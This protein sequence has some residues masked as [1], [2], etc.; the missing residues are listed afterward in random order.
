MGKKKKNNNIIKE[1][2]KQNQDRIAKLMESKLREY[3]VIIPDTNI[4][5]IGVDTLEFDKLDEDVKRYILHSSHLF[6]SSLKQLFKEK[7]VVTTDLVYN[8]LNARVGMIKD[9]VKIAKSPNQTKTNLYVW[10]LKKIKVP[11]P[12]HGNLVKKL[13]IRRKQYK[14]EVVRANPFKPF[15]GLLKRIKSDLEEL[16]RMLH[17]EH[18]NDEKLSLLRSVVD[19]L[20]GKEN[21]PSDA[22]LSLLYLS[23]YVSKNSKNDRCL[24]LTGDKGIREVY[25]SLNN[26]SLQSYNESLFDFSLGFM[27]YS[28][29][30]FC[31]TLYDKLSKNESKVELL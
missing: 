17:V 24:L 25:T 28:P 8:E 10:E 19:K 15:L 31:F 30:V 29:K 2:A 4:F 6:L 9:L 20:Y 11:N 16:V 14:V 27:F 3:D 13:S 7:N 18:I 23:D 22:D 21:Q 26:S 12:K 1:C 5:Y